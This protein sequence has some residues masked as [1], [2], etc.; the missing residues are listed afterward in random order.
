MK[1]GIMASL[2]LGIVGRCAA[3]DQPEFWD[4]VRKV[5][6][7]V[8]I[9]RTYSVGTTAEVVLLPDQA[10]QLVFSENTAGVTEFL[11]WYDAEKLHLFYW[12]SDD[13][14]SSTF[15]TTAKSRDY[16]IT[17]Q[18]GATSWMECTTEWA[19]KDG[20]AHMTF[21]AKTLS[22]AELNKNM[23][24][25]RER[26]WKRLRRVLA[27]DSDDRR[28][29]VEILM[30]DPGGP[31]MVKLRTAYGLDK[32]VAKA[33]DEY[34]KLR[35]ILE[36]AHDRWQHHGNNEPSRS[37][38]LTILEEASNGARFRCVEYAIVVA[39][40][41]R[42][43]GMPSRVLS[44]KTEEVESAEFG[45]GHVVAEVWLDQFDKWVFA[46]GQ[47]DAI[48]EK[49]GI[50]LNAVEFQDAIARNATG[51]Q[52]R[53]RSNAEAES[54]M[55]W[56]VPYLYYFD[57]NRDQRFFQENYEQRRYAPEQGKIMLVPKGAKEPKVFQR[58]TPIKNCTYISNPRAF[59]PP[60]NQ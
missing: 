45:A 36:W 53:S 28:P 50:P 31:E 59:Y 12:Y 11:F 35:I 60:M 21:I 29:P 43:L 4:T 51:L 54:Y 47:R 41:A 9:K 15:L 24:A 14:Y 6:G 16:R 20:K 18:D 26:K 17:A 37:D 1:T 52:I 22:K 27:W 56:I 19:P 25:S 10:A 55:L 58:T 39:A 13:D 5:E 7:K 2:V 38:P 8:T 3:A 33:G 34:E 40:S 32:L 57:F 46:D 42:S 44:L 23:K 30:D 48:P 49:D